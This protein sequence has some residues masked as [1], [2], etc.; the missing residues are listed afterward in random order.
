[1]M[2]LTSLWK[3]SGSWNNILFVV[4]TQVII[5]FRNRTWLETDGI[6]IKNG[7][8]AG[9]VMRPPVNH[10]NV[11]DVEYVAGGPG[12]VLD[13]LALK[14]LVE[15]GF[16]ISECYENTKTRAEDMQLGLCFSLIG[17]FTHIYCRMPI[18]EG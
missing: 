18:D 13:R 17:E 10:R 11:L 1:M 2:I 12:Y 5:S 16:S 6:K 15:Q 7:L 8:Y 4:P 14:N 3:T 9:T